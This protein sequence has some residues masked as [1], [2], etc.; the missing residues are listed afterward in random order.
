MKIF[1]D[2]NV[3]VSGF[4]TRGLCADLIRLVLAEHELVVGE[5]VLR[6]LKRVLTRKIELPAETIQ[7]IIA[8]LEQQTVQPTPKAVSSI[9]VRDEDDQWVLASALAAKVEVLVTGDKD[10][11]DIA[12][13]VTGLTITDPRGF[14]LFYV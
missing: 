1:L 9:P 7:E 8:F 11:L 12:A 6:E 2:T 10:L 3:L 5:V 14:W 4:A 13:K